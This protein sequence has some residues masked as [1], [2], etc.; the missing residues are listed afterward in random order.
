QGNTCFVGTLF[1]RVGGM[2]DQPRTRC[3][4]GMPHSN[5]STLRINSVGGNAKF[6]S[7]MNNDGGTY[8]VY[9]D[10]VEFFYSPTF[11]IQRSHWSIRWLCLEGS[12]RPCHL[13]DRP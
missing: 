5:S 3:P 9:L 6:I 13:A 4:D 8:F 1:K 7:R 11:T 10:D 2:N 12:I